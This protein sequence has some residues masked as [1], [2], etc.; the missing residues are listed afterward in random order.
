MKEAVVTE[1]IRVRQDRVSRKAAVTDA[2]GQANVKRRSERVQG[3]PAPNYNEDSLTVIDREPGT[4]GAR[5]RRL[6]KGGRFG[7]RSGTS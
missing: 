7:I 4:G 6:I 2:A 1:K 5:D 3:Q